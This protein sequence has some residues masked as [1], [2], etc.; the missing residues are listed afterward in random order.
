VRYT[1]NGAA[2]GPAAVVLRL[3]PRELLELRG[4]VGVDQR[5][6]L[7]LH[8]Q[9][10]VGADPT[11]RARPPLVGQ[12]VGAEAQVQPRIP[13]VAG[14]DGRRVPF[15]GRRPIG[16]DTTNGTLVR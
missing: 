10:D 12:F 4:S 7:E 1:T 8:V 11:A 5:A 15:R 9:V 16:P 13:R 14:C 6:R 2:C 3:D